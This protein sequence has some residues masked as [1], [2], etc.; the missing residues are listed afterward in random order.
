MKKLS[1][2]LVFLLAFV[3]LLSGTALAAPEAPFW[4]FNNQGG[5]QEPS[6]GLLTDI[7]FVDVHGNLH[8]SATPDDLYA[9]GLAEGDLL[10]VSIGVGFI[11]EMPM[12]SLETDV[13]I[14]EDMLLA[15]N[16]ELVV[17][18]RGGS[19]TN[20]YDLDDSTKVH[21]FLSEAG[22]YLEEYNARRGLFSLEVAPDYTDSQYWVFHDDSGD[23]EADVFMIGP[24]MDFGEAGNYNMSLEDPS[25]LQSYLGEMQRERGLFEETCNLWAPYYRLA[26]LP[27]FTME[28]DEQQEYLDFAYADVREAFIH[29][30]ENHNNGRPIILMGFSQGGYMTTRLIAEF[31]GDEDLRR[32]L[33]AVYAIGWCITQEDVDACSWLNMAQGETDLGV[34]ISFECEAEGND[35]GSLSVPAGTK[36]LSINPLSWSTDTALAHRSENDGSVFMDASGRVVSRFTKLTGAYIDPERGTLICPDLNA[37]FFIP[38]IPMFEYGEYHPYDYEIFYENLKENIALRLSV[39]LGTDPGP[40]S[41]ERHLTECLIGTGLVLA[42]LTAALLLE[43]RRKKKQ[44]LLDA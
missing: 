32:Q 14:G 38:D 6:I 31:F 19:I 20:A 27:V 28:E 15:M 37:R 25:H 1:R 24:T 44:Q 22:G 4:L 2:A 39:F 29:Y 8:L 41:M 13:D 3:T 11:L 7:D 21:I 42:F 12:V 33:V 36:M 16:G 43:H 40:T 30:L 9:L 26:T 18:L 10:Y 23:K 34:V 5:S 17:Q 35:D